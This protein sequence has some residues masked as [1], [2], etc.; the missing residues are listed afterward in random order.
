M[1]DKRQKPGLLVALLAMLGIFSLPQVVKMQGNEPVVRPR[2]ADMTRSWHG[3]P[4]AEEPQERDR[5]DLRPLI[6]FL[7]EGEAKPSDTADL[8]EYLDRKLSQ[9]RCLVVTVPDP[10]ESV[11][12]ARF[13]EFLDVVQRGIELQEF[14]LDRTLLPWE[15]ATKDRESALDR[16]SRIRWDRLG[17]D[18]QIDTT[19]LA[20][21][22]RA[23]PGLMVFK[24]ALLPGSEP[25]GTPTVVLA[26]LVR[27]SPIL[28]VEKAELARSLDLIDQ[29]FYHKLTG[30]SEQVLNEK[31]NPVL[32]KDQSPLLRK[33]CRQVLHIV[34][35]CFSGSQTSIQFALGAW[36][37]PDDRSYHFRIISGGANQ[38]E[39]TRLENL[40]AANHRHRLT[41]HSMVHPVKLVMDEMLGYLE[42]SLGYEATRVAVLVESN[43]GLI[44]S[45][46][47]YRNTQPVEFIFPL[48]ISELR[49]AYEREG[50]I[51]GGKLN[52][53]SAPSG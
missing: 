13:D 30:E 34:G 4:E 31:G 12:S 50:L 26:F 53:A 40:F 16:T 3:V 27:E 43:S 52:D 29:F 6:E 49:K 44:Q 25:P 35:P 42:K 39:K 7:A 41:F 48:Q 15:P 9:V 38:V 51:A 5:R 23:R 11:A 10:V 37:N 36:K 19:R 2:D 18:F 46:F 1:D 21:Q 14:V 17:L 47:R 33:T 45:L 24:K 8:H 28:G 20:R 32:E 22:D